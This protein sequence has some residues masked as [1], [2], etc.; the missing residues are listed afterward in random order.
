[1]EKP[2][3]IN[4]IYM[5]DVKETIKYRFIILEWLTH[6]IELKMTVVL[7]LKGVNWERWKPKW[8]TQLGYL[9][10]YSKRNKSIS[11][12]DNIVNVINN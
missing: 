3:V 11:I 9:F 12:I 6:L 8:A 7:S 5:T 2:R 1:M 10:G 4:I